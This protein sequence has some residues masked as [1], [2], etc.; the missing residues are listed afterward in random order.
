M[1]AIRTARLTRPVALLIAAA[2]LC[3][4]AGNTR[5]AATLPPNQ[6]DLTP[7]PALHFGSL[8]NGLRYIIMKNAQPKG[9]ASLR[10]LVNA[11]S[12]NETEQQ[13]GLAHFLEHMAFNGSRHF[14]SGSLIETLQRMGMGSARDTN[15][16]TTYDHTLYQLELPDVSE[17][18]LGTGLDFLQDIAAYL[19]LTPDR[20]NKERGIILS[21]KR[22]R[23]SAA[24][25][26]SQFRLDHLYAGTLLAARNPIGLTSVIEGATHRQLKEFYDT[27]YRPERMTVVAVGDFDVSAIENRVRARFSALT[28]RAPARK[29]PPIG[30]PQP[31]ESLDAYYNYSPEEAQTQVQILTLAPVDHEED[32]RATR[33]KYLP[34]N[35]A[36][37]MMN[38]R[39]ERLAKAEKTPFLGAS[40]NAADVFG[41]REVSISAASKADEWR[42]SLAAIEQQLR[43]A[44]AYGFR[45]DELT[46]VV[47]NL[48]GNMEEGVKA[49]ATR[50]S[51]ELADAVAS[52][53]QG[54]FVFMA[55]ADSL[56]LLRPALNAVTVDQCAAAFRDAWAAGSRHIG[57]EGNAKIDDA[58]RA[59]VDAYAEAAAV[60][61]SETR[62]ATAIAQ[63]WGYESFGDPGS[64]VRREHVGDLDVTLV[65]L[66]NGVRLN[67]KKTDYTANKVVMS[68]RV[69]SGLLSLPPGRVGLPGLA[70][71]TFLQG[72]TGKHSMDEMRRLLAGR[73]VD[74]GFHVG[75]DAFA[76]SGSSSRSDLPQA[77]RV[78]AAEISDPGYRPEALWLARRGIEKI[79]DAQEHSL[80]GPFAKE[81]AGL[82]VSNDFR[83][84]QPPRSTLLGYT[85]DDV[86]GW[87]GPEVAHGPIEIAIV[88]DLDVEE[89]VATVARTLGTLPMRETT[90]PAVHKARELSFPA[91]P[92]HREYR[93]PTEDSVGNVA[94]FWPTTDGIEVGRA[95]RLT[96]LGAVLNERLRSKIREQLGA[97]YSPSASSLASD[98]FPGYGYV[99]ASASID[100]AIADR[101]A[102]VMVAVADDMSRN[103]IS[104]D[105]LRKVKIPARVELQEGYRS[106]SYWLSVLS[107]AQGRPEVL[108]WVRTRMADFDAISEADVN[109]LAKSYLSA[110]RASRFIALPSDLKG[111]LG[112]QPMNS[113]NPPGAPKL[114]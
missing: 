10:L 12:L 69:G 61:V 43:Q 41:V 94:V 45:P 78:I 91:V 7:D 54:K 64:V 86:R 109:A 49:A 9:Q 81:V 107:Q 6:S 28:P 19:D 65:T 25:R 71:M 2:L 84:L 67:I 90:L 106:N 47:T 104:G 98:I 21:E 40:V 73:T 75:I 27:W 48:I 95:R 36:I 59:I 76:F 62:V 42:T 63:R 66:A 88:G 8:P 51:G 35:L 114:P 82:L 30:S 60:P 32:T 112:S 102:D 58:R 37:L 44:L 34:R 89:A 99:T 24:A 83:Y 15:A 110:G 93:V 16:A 26:M 17:K 97:S 33:L 68:V 92:F 87:L 38:R 100:P 14:R 53:V 57:V 70:E 1:A 46:E 74:V 96:V 52:S 111:S 3:A 80:N 20:I 79:Y 18:T 101:L 29:E 113:D 103:G 56:A 39:L 50:Q 4:A 11:G 55:P 13:R 31:A 5:A 23:D 77:L 22:T 72:G 105:E 108:D 85:L